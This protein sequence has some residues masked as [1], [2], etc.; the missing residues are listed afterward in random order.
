MNFM[1]DLRKAKEVQLSSPLRDD[2]AMLHENINVEF[3]LPNGLEKI[4]VCSVGETVDM[5]RER[6]AA[7]QHCS[8]ECSFYH[9]GT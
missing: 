6:L 2:S 5:I 4:F 3:V 7:N 8:F 1:I 9:E